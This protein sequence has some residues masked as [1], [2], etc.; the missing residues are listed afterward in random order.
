MSNQNNIQ[1][2]RVRKALT[3]HKPDSI[4]LIFAIMMAI[5]GA[6]MIFDASVYQANTVFNDQFYFLKSQLIWLVIGIIPA[7][8]IY[9]WDYRKILKLAFPALIITIILLVLVLVLGE[10][11]N[12]SKRWFAIGSLPKIQ[13][14][15]FAK[16]TLIMYLSSW[17]AKRDY[18]YKDFKSALREGFIKNLLG[19]LAILGTVA[20]LILLEPDLG[21]TMILCITCFIMFLMAG[22]D[23]IHTL[24]SGSVLLLLV[25]VG[26]LAAILE[27]Y[28]LKRVITFLSLL[29]TGNV[30]DPQGSGYQMQQ[31]LIGI[32]SGGL[33]GT[34]FGQS[35]QR[36]G[37]LVENTA[38]TDS[39]FAVIL[40]EL[41]FLGGTLIILAWLVFLWRGL[42]IAMA[43]PD[44]EGKLL[45]AG[46]TVW[47][48]MQTLL[49]IAAN[50]GFIPLTGMPIPFLSYGGS[51]TIVSLI[52]IGILLNISKYSNTQNGQTKVR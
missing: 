42:K 28:R 36:F 44:K 49:N 46:I 45:A 23:K 1:K 11:L 21:T 29:F 32:G 39:I 41:G 48:V 7:V 10:A 24:A 50:V 12:G 14:A 34:G 3:G 15:E 22:E 31:I 25:P 5:F 30:A 35:R 37:Y 17:L 20:I 16:I 9:F 51:S 19:F 27:P 38:F 47:L 33:F 2:R 4:I 43:A 13:P 40:E 18:K 6:I 52:G 26:A 8:L